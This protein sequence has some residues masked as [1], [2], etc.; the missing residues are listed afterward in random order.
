MARL[1]V[2]RRMGLDRRRPMVDRRQV[3]RQAERLSGLQESG[4]AASGPTEQVSHTNRA[5][6]GRTTRLASCSAPIARSWAMNSSN[7]RSIGVFAVFR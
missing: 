3:Y 6:H 4:A 5:R 1:R 7:V 2:I